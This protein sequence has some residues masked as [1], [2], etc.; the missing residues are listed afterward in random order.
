MSHFTTLVVI[1][2]FNSKTDSLTDRLEEALAPYMENCCAEPDRKYMEF[3]DKE[4]E[5]KKEYET[6]TIRVVRM[7]DGELVHLHDKRWRPKPTTKNPFP[8]P[9][10]PKDQQ[11]EVKISRMYKTFESFAEEYN[12][13]K[14]D[15]ITGKYGYWQNPNARW[16]WYEIGGRWSGFF[17]LKAGRDGLQGKQYNLGRQYK[18]SR[19]AD[20]CF[21]GDV[22]VEGMRSAAAERAQLKWEKVRKI[23]GGGWQFKTWDEVK[24]KFGI[25]PGIETTPNPIEE[26]RK[27]Y[28][29]QPS[30]K[31][32]REYGMS[33]EGRN[34]ELVN[35]FEGPDEYRVP[36]GD[37]IALA[38]DHA[39][40]TFA[41]VKDGKWAE[42]GKMGWWAVVSNEKDPETWNSVYTKMFDSLSD[43]TLLCLCD[44]HI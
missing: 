36:I 7:F 14:K 37:Y 25:E 13:Y 22:D 40:V 26:A 8:Q 30:V 43:D 4:D 16:D 15:D 2:K 17:W 27:F 29:D 5:M 24:E 32:F 33:E 21:K 35:F 31:K 18:K 44:C 41:F 28:W 11:M 38:R 19:K 34:D 42:Q 10:P 12:G 6:K 1:E 39:I 9:K 3:Y 20:V 23:I